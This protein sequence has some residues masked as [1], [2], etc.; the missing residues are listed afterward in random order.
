MIRLFAFLKPFRISVALVLVLI[1]L[2]SLANLYLPNLMSDIVDTGIAKGNVSYIF[3]IGGFMLLFT[4]AGVLFSVAAS[5]LAAKVSSGFG[6]ILRAKVFSH[7]EG[8]VL[9]EFDQIGTASLITRTTNDI[10]QVQ[11]FVNM[12]LRMMVMTQCLMK[13]RPISRRDKNNC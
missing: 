13:K 10:T 11:Q 9:H 3:Q 8:F 12:F 5:W 2:Q 4:I 7:V 6:K 1:F